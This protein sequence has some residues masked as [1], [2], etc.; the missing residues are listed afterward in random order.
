MSPVLTRKRSYPGRRILVPLLCAAIFAWGLQAKLSLYNT[1]SSS[2][3]TSVAKLIQNEPAKK[4]N[5]AVGPGVRADAG[6]LFAYS[7]VVLLQPRFVVC[8]NRQV[9][10]LICSSI[11]SYS[12]ALLFRPPPQNA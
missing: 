10:K 4:K 6:Q 1:G 11:S 9:H 3:P 2:H 7:A 12:H 5:S 8:R